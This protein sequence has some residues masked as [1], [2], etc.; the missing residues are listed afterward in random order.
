M[1][2][3]CAEEWNSHQSAGY[4]ACIMPS[5]YFWS[6]YLLFMH[7]YF[8]KVESTVRIQTF[9]GS[10]ERQILEESSQKSIFHVT[11]ALLK[12]SRLRSRVE[13]QSTRLNDKALL[14]MG[15]MKI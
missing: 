4:L 11:K 7:L 9:L 6:A 10:P 13:Y 12:R 8:L 5:N 14:I 2:I 15:D 3:E 1:S